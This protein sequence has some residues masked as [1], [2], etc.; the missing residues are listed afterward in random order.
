MHLQD[1]TVTVYFVLWGQNIAVIHY[2]RQT[3]LFRILKLYINI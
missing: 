3:H 2:S 1:F